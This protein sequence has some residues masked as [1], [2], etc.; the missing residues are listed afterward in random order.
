[1]RHLASSKARPLLIL[2]L[3]GALGVSA[4]LPSCG[5]H[6]CGDVG[7]GPMAT[8]RIGLPSAPTMITPFRVV[9]CLGTDCRATTVPGD[10]NFSLPAGPSGGP[11]AAGT[12]S[13]TPAGTLIMTIQ[14]TPFAQGDGTNGDH[15]TV[16]VFDQGGDVLG[17]VDQQAIYT[18]TYPNGKDCGPACKSVMLE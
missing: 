9:A 10:N 4:L 16:R 15:Y 12:L 8:I 1:M 14:W 18:T 2:A 13:I 17:F 3:L 5:S 11:T 6:A 7:C